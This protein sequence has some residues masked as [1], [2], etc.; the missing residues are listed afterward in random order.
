M[1]TECKYVF[2]FNELNKFIIVIY[3]RFNL[4]ILF[5]QEDYDMYH[6]LY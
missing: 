5:N 6:L 1:F 2:S 3:Q 4:L